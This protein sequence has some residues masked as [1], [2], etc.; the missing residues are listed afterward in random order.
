M[1]SLAGSSGGR[2]GTGLPWLLL[3]LEERLLPGPELD[4][5]ITRWCFA[6]PVTC[7]IALNRRELVP[8][9]IQVLNQNARVSRWGGGKK[10]RN[11][12]EFAYTCAHPSTKF[13]F[14]G[15][16]TFSLN[17]GPTFTWNS[18]DCWKKRSRR[19][20]THVQHPRFTR[21]HS[22][23]SANWNFR[24]R[25]TH[26]IQFFPTSRA[27]AMMICARS[28]LHAPPSSLPGYCEFIK[29]RI[30]SRQDNLLRGLGKRTKSYEGFVVA[31]YCQVS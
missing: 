20:R 10:H 23:R 15:I 21:A 8:Q 30:R 25:D 12:M 6:Q 24:S 3:A 22:P 4:V 13:G 11:Y 14:R 2:T 27:R 16:K 19:K 18:A 5:D 26:V 28:F 1:F 7:M 9:T 17:V 31:A 29:V